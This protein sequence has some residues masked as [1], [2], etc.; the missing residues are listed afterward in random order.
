MHNDTTPAARGFPDH[1]AGGQRQ[2]IRRNTSLYRSGDRVTDCVFF[3]HAGS[4]KHYRTDETGA[5]KI[6]CFPA[7]GDFLALDSIGLDWHPCTAVAL[8][9]S[10]VYVISYAILRQQLTILHHLLA[11][12]IREMRAGTVQMHQATA[13][14][15]LAAFLLE[16]ARHTRLE[17]TPPCYRLP[18]SRCDIGNYLHLSPES[19]SRV[20]HHFKQAGLILLEN[21]YIA[22][23]DAGAMETIA[24]A[25]HPASPHAARP[26]FAISH[27]ST[28]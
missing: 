10:E 22:L 1:I 4:F 7:R 26:P 19:V 11:L 23:L 21:R 9:D 3:I 2:W 13:E 25:A 5:R 18:M 28:S 6:T 15:R 14:Q 17:G 27:S 24:T 12:S 20:M 16:R 8:E